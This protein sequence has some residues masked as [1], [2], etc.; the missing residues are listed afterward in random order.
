ME[1]N[2]LNTDILR[3]D[4]NISRS[5]SDQEQITDF[6]D[7]TICPPLV[8]SL[9]DKSNK[10]YASISD[11]KTGTDSEHEFKKKERQKPKKAKQNELCI[12]LVK[13][14]S[15]GWIRE[16]I[17]RNGEVSNVYYL[18]P[19]SGN[20]RKR[21]RIR[22]KQKLAAFLSSTTSDLS[23]SN[24][25]TF[26]LKPLGLGVQKEVMREAKSE[27][28]FTYETKAVY[29]FWKEI[30]CEE[31]KLKQKDKKLKHKDKK[32]HCSLCNIKIGYRSFQVHMINCHLPEE[33]CEICGREF[34][35]KIFRQHWEECEGDRN[36][37]IM[38]QE[39]GQDG[40]DAVT[41]SL[42]KTV[43]DA[44]KNEIKKRNNDTSMESSLGEGNKDND[45]KYFEGQLP[46]SSKLEKESNLE[47]WVKLKMT[48]VSEPPISHVMLLKSSATILRAMKKFSSILGRSFQKL[49]FWRLGQMLTGTELAGKM[50][51]AQVLVKAK[52]C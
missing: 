34:P 41:V 8:P 32:G 10:E 28:C 26:V 50:E 47:S 14:L 44:T 33:S 39:R 45:F 13:P 25:F 2:N 18:T 48:L 23:G 1:D 40:E 19:V 29:N 17:L 49:E 20:E 30:Q 16:C 9:T 15:E 38:E 5:S 4:L 37:E 7:G 3:E 24:N 11:G 46:E 36:R 42:E 27:A 35:A 31:K 6:T 12:D 52:M 21:K 43:V 51:G 22:N